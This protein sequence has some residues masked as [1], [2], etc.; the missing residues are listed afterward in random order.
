MTALSLSFAY[1]ATLLS[2]LAFVAWRRWLGARYANDAV[3]AEA[4]ALATARDA[5]VA[6]LKEDVGLLRLKAGL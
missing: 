4:K 6:Q 3:L 2:A 1:V 5:E